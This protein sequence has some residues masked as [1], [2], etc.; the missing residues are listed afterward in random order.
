MNLTARSYA[1]RAGSIP[2]RVIQFFAANLGEHMD[3]ADIAVKFDTPPHSVST[4]LKS[5]LDAGF[6]DKQGGRWCAGEDIYLAPD[7]GKLAAID[8]TV[9]TAATS[10]G[11]HNPFASPFQ[12]ATASVKA[13][14]ARQAV[15]G[16]QRAAPDLSGLQIDDGIELVATLVRRNPW[17]P[18]F[19]A[20]TRP[21]QSAVIAPEWRTTIRAHAKNREKT[22]QGRYQIGIDAQGNTRILR[23]A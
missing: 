3:S 18:L 14:K 9:A 22:G 17:A 19:E 4:L 21:G 2:A 20:L 15:R 8:H 16:P 23:T 10:S 1:P 11:A 7:F 5:A 12:A 13:I 6:V